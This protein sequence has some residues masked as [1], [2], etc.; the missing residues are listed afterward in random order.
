MEGAGVLLVL[1]AGGRKGEEVADGGRALEVVAVGLDALMGKEADLAAEVLTGGG[2]LG[3]MFVVVTV[4]GGREGEEIVV[5]DVVGVN[6]FV[7]LAVLLVRRA[8]GVREEEGNNMKVVGDGEEVAVVLLGGRVVVVDGG[9]AVTGLIVLS[10]VLVGKENE[11]EEEEGGGKVKDDPAAAP[12]PGDGADLPLALTLKVKPVLPMKDLLDASPEL[13]CFDPSPTL[14]WPEDSSSLSSASPFF[15]WVLSPSG[16]SVASP[17]FPF[18][19]AP[20]AT[21]LCPSRPF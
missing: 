6:E 4:I 12:Q 11:K 14:L 7:A 10:G 13:C 19:S 16:S 1:C 5:V 20:H 8:E 18:L 21:H 9:G 17:S 2:G 3:W 15:F